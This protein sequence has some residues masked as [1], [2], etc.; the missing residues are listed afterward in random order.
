MTANHFSSAPAIEVLELWEKGVDPGNGIVAGQ[1]AGSAWPL[2]E[3]WVQRLSV[4][5]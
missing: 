1:S 3:R 4:A 5:K 2:M